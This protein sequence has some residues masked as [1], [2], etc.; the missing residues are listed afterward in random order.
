MDLRQVTVRQEPYEIFFNSSKK[1]EASANRNTISVNVGRKTILL[2]NAM[3]KDEQGEKI[4]PVELAFQVT[5]QSVC[6]D[7]TVC[8]VVSLISLFVRCF[9]C[10]CGGFTDFTVCVVISLSVR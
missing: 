5:C 6:G 7:S 8:A 4:E 2:V 3:G 9:H 1:G 10:V